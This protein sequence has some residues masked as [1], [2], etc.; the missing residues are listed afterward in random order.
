[1]PSGGGSTVFSLES[2]NTI[3]PPG[4]RSLDRNRRSNSNTASD[5]GVSLDSTLEFLGLTVEFTK[6]ESKVKEVG[7]NSIA[8]RAG[9]KAGDVIE[10]IDGNAVKKDTKLKGEGVKSFVVR[11]DGKRLNLKIGN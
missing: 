11:R 4:F 6:G 2:A 5:T 9:L 1:M 10:T 3:S 7:E 8:A